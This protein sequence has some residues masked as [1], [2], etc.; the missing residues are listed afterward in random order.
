LT[1]EEE[2]RR[3]R[4][5]LHDGLGPTL[6]SQT[7]TMDVVLDLLETDPQE[8]ARLVR[9]L[10]SQNQETVAE[11]RRLVYELRPPA[12]DELGLTGALEAHVSQ[13]NRSQGLRIQFF[14]QPD[15]LPSLSAAVEV[16]AYRISLEGITN[17]VRHAKAQRCDVFLRLEKNGRSC[18]VI[19]ISDDGI[20]IFPEQQPGVGLNSMRERAE[21]LGGSCRIAAAENG[22][23]KV[24]AVLPISVSTRSRR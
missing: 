9:G 8:A 5:D 4:R 12:L 14:T 7:F 18:L 20:G 19:D 2:R 24:T 11:I 21:E 3:I 1:R 6:A 15:P 23:T 22:G 13:L 10:K 17:V 16:A